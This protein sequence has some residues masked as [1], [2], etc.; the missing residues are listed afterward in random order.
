LPDKPHRSHSTE[1]L[2]QRGLNLSGFSGGELISEDLVVKTDLILAV[3]RRFLWHF[4]RISYF[5]PFSS[6][7][8]SVWKNK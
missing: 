8:S 7:F 5:N 6:L 1:N 4:K 2:F 3:Y